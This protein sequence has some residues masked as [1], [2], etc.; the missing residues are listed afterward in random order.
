VP[1]RCSQDYSFTSAAPLKHTYHVSNSTLISINQERQNPFRVISLVLSFSDSP[2]REQTDPTAKCRH[3]ELCQT[4]HSPSNFLIPSMAFL[5][6]CYMQRREH[7]ALR[8]NS[9]SWLEGNISGSASKHHWHMRLEHLRP[10]T[11]ALRWTNSSITRQVVVPEQK[12]V[13]SEITQRHG[14]KP[15]NH[16]TLLSL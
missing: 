12:N 8:W 13:G 1:V 6:A 10:L 7:P 4:S 11:Y 15:T 16:L 14:L 5:S 3:L 9:W 2:T